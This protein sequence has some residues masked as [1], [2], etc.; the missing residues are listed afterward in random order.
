MASE[1]FVHY[2]YVHTQTHTGNRVD[3]QTRE[4]VCVY[5][6]VCPLISPHRIA[7]SH[8]HVYVSH[9]YLGVEARNTLAV[10]CDDTL[11]CAVTEQQ[12]SENLHTKRD[13]YFATPLKI[14]MVQSRVCSVCAYV[15]CSRGHGAKVQSE[16]FFN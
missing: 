6:C 9:Y 16:I 10:A 4:H 1:A 12:S 8:I 7:A 11:R 2:I 15:I 13:L 5:C 3:R 14:Y